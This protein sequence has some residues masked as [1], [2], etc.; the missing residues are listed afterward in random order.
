MSGSRTTV[1]ELGSRWIFWTPL[2]L[3]M[4]QEPSVVRNPVLEIL[5]DISHILGAR[6]S[7]LDQ[8]AFGLEWLCSLIASTS[9]ES[10]WRHKRTPEV[11]VQ[12]SCPITL[13]VSAP[14]QV[15]QRWLNVGIL[16]MWKCAIPLREDLQSYNING[17]NSRKGVIWTMLCLFSKELRKPALIY[18]FF[19]NDLSQHTSQVI[20]RSWYMCVYVPLCKWL[21]FPLAPFVCCPV[22]PFALSTNPRIKGKCP[23]NNLGS[24]IDHDYHID[25]SC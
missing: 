10:K 6:K 12:N 22:F 3:L 14:K 23:F 19:Y 1:K 15:T 21:R 24:S 13:L 11:M 8:G 16:G 7:W 25:H 2:W 18:F 9:Q 4:F 5:T 20:W 17:L